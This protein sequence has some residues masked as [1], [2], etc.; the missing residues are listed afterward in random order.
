MSENRP[1]LFTTIVLLVVVF[2][3]IS[4]VYSIVDKRIT[5]AEEYIYKIS[6]LEEKVAWTESEILDLKK[7]QQKMYEQKL[8]MTPAR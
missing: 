2:G 6:V 1:D 7:P 4:L 3:L 5:N 8:L